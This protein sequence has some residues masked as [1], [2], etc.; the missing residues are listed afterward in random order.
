M[1]KILLSV[2]ALMA[3]GTLAAQNKATMIVDADNHKGEINRHIYGHF[4]EHLGSGIYGGIWVGKNSSIPNTNGYRN[5]V[6]SALK[7]LHIPN[8]R[9][10]GGCFADEYHWMNGIGP[11]SERARM[12]NTHW[13]GVVE[14]NSFGTHEFLDLC[15]LLGTEPYICGNVG[16]GTVREMA[17][18][19]EYITFDG[20]SPMADLRRKNGRTQ[21]WK[22]KFW[23][24][25]NENWG[26]GGNMRP[27]FYAD[28]YRQFATYARNF[29]DNRLFKIAGGANVDDYNWTEVC[30]RTIGYRMNGISLHYYTIPTGNWGKKGSATQYDNSEYLATVRNTMYMNELLTRHSNI[31]DRYD[32]EK[33]TAL[34]VDEWGIWSDVEPGTNPGFLYQQS[35]MRDAIVAGLNFNMFHEHNDR[36]QV[37]NIA[38][39]V[40]VLQSI[41]L[42]KDDKMVLTPTYYAFDMYKNHMDATLVDSRVT[43]DMVSLGTPVRGRASEAPALNVTSSVKDG[44]MTISIVNIDPSKD[45]DLS[46]E[47]R[48]NRYSSASG[49]VLT[50]SKLQDHNTFETPNVVTK[51]ALSGVKLS[52]NTLTAKIPSK[53]VVTLV[54][55]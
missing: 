46:C 2:I 27:E 1:K 33:R 31:M 44:V 40:N 53:S 5:D 32:P 21:P 8:L 11:L 48:G 30:M 22:V 41:I 26:C 36:V 12:I 25:G 39:M 10:P 28:L 16:S 20:E 52:N 55:K 23:G 54:L 51:K 50:S 19:V 45:F 6:V 7:N 9:W 14:D 38:Q 49:E 34:V 13:G 24:V 15:E 29:G 3:A 37:A 18:W 43:S 17:D 35:T 4:A 47:I 42:T